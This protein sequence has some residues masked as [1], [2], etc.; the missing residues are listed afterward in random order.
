MESGKELSGFST[1]PD[2]GF[3]A[4]SSDGEALAIRSP[5]GIALWHT[6]TGKQLDIRKG[7]QP[8]KETNPFRPW[9]TGEFP[10]AWYGGHDVLSP[11]GKYLAWYI[12]KTMRGVARLQV[13]ETASG[14]KLHDSML[15]EK[16]GSNARIGGFS[17]DGSKLLLWGDGHIWVLD[18]H[19]DK[20]SRRIPLDRDN[21]HYI[22]LS[23]D[24]RYIVAGEGSGL[25]RLFDLDRNKTARLKGPQGY[26]T[27]FAF[28]H[29]SKRLFSGG[30]DNTVLA[31]DLTAIPEKD[32][33]SLPV[34]YLWWI[35][36]AGVVLLALAVLWKI[37]SLFRGRWLQSA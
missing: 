2:S 17:A 25:I 5:G 11:D 13:W 19:T 1:G 16:D 20:T 27:A 8:A 36:A 4:L 37:L 31:W 22:A 24:G 29:D 3:V 28:S 15:A 7:P 23:P 12:Q 18:I 6:G 30:K 35:V 33:E 34:D 26:V 21:S 10:E 9:V 32:F 14:K